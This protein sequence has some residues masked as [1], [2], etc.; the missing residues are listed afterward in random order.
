MTWRR[1]TTCRTEEERDT[2]YTSKEHDSERRGQEEACWRRR[3][4]VHPLQGVASAPG[5]G[6]RGRVKTEGESGREAETVGAEQD[7]GQALWSCPASEVGR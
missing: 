6:E 3:A 1:T 5:P 4:A 2:G 7:G